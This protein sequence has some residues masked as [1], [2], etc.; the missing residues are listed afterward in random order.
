M[1]DKVEIIRFSDGKSEEMEDLVASE[2]PLTVFLNDEQLITLLCS[3]DKLEYLALGFLLSEGFIRT[4]EDVE[5]I[6]LDKKT[7][8]VR[9]AIKDIKRIEKEMVFGRRIITSGCGKGMTFFDFKDFSQCRKIE[10]GLVVAPE[11]IL[12]LTSE[13]QKRS[14]VFRET[15]GVHSA[16]LSDGEKILFFAEDLGRH[17][18]LDKIF[19]QALW[20]GVDPE[21]KMLLTSGRLS[22]EIT[23]KALKRGVPLIVSPSAPTDLAV[24][25]ARQMNLTLIGFTRGRRMNLYSAPAR[26]K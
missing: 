16:A 26:V 20:E 7:T 5:S 18:A 1:K 22:S 24:R 9:V 21:G 4:K 25:I 11:K 15:G 10:S 19:G 8:T 3:P 14:D 2:V 12:S 17:N 13:F 23:I 6:S